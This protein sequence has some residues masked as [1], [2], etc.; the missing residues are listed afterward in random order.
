MQTFTTVLAATLLT[1]SIPVMRGLPP[2]I[3]WGIACVVIS[4][5]LSVATHRKDHGLEMALASN[6]PG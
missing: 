6:R 1:W 4:G 3:G 5:M 2:W